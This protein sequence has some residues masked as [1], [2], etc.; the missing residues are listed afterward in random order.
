MSIKLVNVI[1]RRKLATLLFSLAI[2]ALTGMTTLGI[3]TLLNNDYI[4]VE[5]IATGSDWWQTR[6]E[7]PYWLVN[8]ILPGA[9]EYSAGNKKMAE[10]LEVKKYGDDYSKILW[11]KIRLLVTKD[12]INK[13]WRF[14]QQPLT[15][16]SS[17]TINPNNIKLTGNI[18]NITGI[19]K[20]Y[21]TKTVSVNLKIYDRYPWLAEAIK[22]GDSS[23][24]DDGTVDALI[25][26]KNVALAERTIYTSSGKN[27]PGFDPL[28]RDISLVVR[29]NAIE[30]GDILYFNQVQPVK[31]GNKLWIPFKNINIDAAEI[32]G[33]SPLD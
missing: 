11:A 3:K 25:E 29:I 5:I 32:T 28:R 33:F 9:T 2:I 6:P 24:N 1:K 26:D 13:G 30:R 15:I 18:I 16:G 10:I 21:Q 22:I 12:V 4:E 31:I 23:V 8:S 7:A 27:F 17:I 20:D 14:Q 19:N